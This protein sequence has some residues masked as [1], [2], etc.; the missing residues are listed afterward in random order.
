MPG[1]DIGSRQKGRYDLNLAK[2]LQHTE[3]DKTEILKAINSVDEHRTTSMVFG[4]GNST[5]MFMD[6][7]SKPQVWEIEIQKKFYSLDAY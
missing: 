5:E 1:I 6:I 4:G 7:I 2:N 3:H